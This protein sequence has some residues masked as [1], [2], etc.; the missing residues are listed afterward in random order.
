MGGKS[1]KG[2]RSAEISPP[3][4]SRN[5]RSKSTDAESPVSAKG[6]R[7]G[8]RV[9]PPKSTEDNSE[10]DGSDKSVLASESDDEAMTA[11]ATVT[12]A[13]KLKNRT[14][15]VSDAPQE[16]A[17]PAKA[18]VANWLLQISLHHHRRYT[19]MMLPLT[20][21]FDINRQGGSR[22]SPLAEAA[23]TVAAA[24][25]AAQVYHHDAFVDFTI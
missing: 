22:I 23:E 11:N 25:S 5:E 16:K 18:K 9:S 10:A 12:A 24:A 19:T 2:G 6:R 13:K 1:G 8:R 17:P 7:S 3:R 15:I 20:S 4:N 14:K 21:P